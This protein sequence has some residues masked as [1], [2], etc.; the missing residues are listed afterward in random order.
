M[1]FSVLLPTRNGKKYLKSCIKSILDQQYEDFE[2]IVADNSNTDG[3]SEIIDSFSYDNRI[4]H[5][6][7][8]RVLTVTENWL[9]ALRRSDGEYVLM[10]GDDDYLIPGFF[11]RIEDV[12]DEYNSPD[13]ITY[14]GYSF[15]YPNVANKSSIS[16]YSDPHF[17]FEKELSQEKCVNSDFLKEIVKD[18][19]KFNIRVPLNALPHVWS[20]KVIDSV[21][22]DLFRPPYPDHFAINSM[23]LQADSWVFLPDKLYIVGVT[24]KSYGNLVN[25][26]KEQAKNYLGIDD[27]F[28]GKLPGSPLV[29]NMYLWLELLRDNNQEE[30]AKIPVSRD[31]YI[32]HQIFYWLSM[33]RKN[34]VS[35]GDLLKL[36][37][38]L[39]YAELLG[40]IPSLYNKRSINALFMLLN[41]KVTSDGSFYFRQKSIDNI[42]DI[43]S[44]YNNVIKN[45]HFSSR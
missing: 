24:P 41:N 28:Y 25:S 26:K 38:M 6:K 32:K 21:D 12:I 16:F 20:R 19:F 39:S 11:N 42:K 45:D 22:G 30:L 23:F 4:K 15:V 2:L 43:S 44:L 34:E 14:S 1:K 35:F 18:M 17:V 31:Q 5:F 33:Y 7:S 29:N 10:I 3:S 13:G 37:K 40:R 36:F 8:K 27:R 9:E